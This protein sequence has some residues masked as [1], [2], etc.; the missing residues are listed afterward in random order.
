[1]E[2]GREHSAAP[3]I[4]ESPSVWPKP[5]PQDGQ[6]RDKVDKEKCFNKVYVRVERGK[7][8]PEV[9]LHMAGKVTLVAPGSQ[10]PRGP[11]A[12]VCELAPQP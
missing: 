8:I 5:A 1:V 4:H 12:L 2:P 3:A 10:V 9:W 6:G 11:K 7:P